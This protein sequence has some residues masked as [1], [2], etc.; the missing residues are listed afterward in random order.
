MAASLALR[1]VTKRLGDRLILDRVDVEVA[2]GEIVTVIGPNGSGKSTL[3]RIALGLLAPDGGA[4]ERRPGLRIGY[5]PQRVALSPLM[6]M[7]ARRFLA[8]HPGVTAAAMDRAF[9]LV[10]LDSGLAQT[11]VHHLSGGEFQRLLLARALL[12]E[13]SLLVLDEPTQGVDLTGQAAFYRL[14][15]RVR[16]ELQCAVLLISHDL[17]LVM[18]ATDRVVCL[19]HHVCCSGV[20]DKVRRDPAFRA[21]F[22][23]EAD[24]LALYAHDHAHA[25]DHDHDHDHDHEHHS[26]EGQA[27]G[28]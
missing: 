11:S 18:A 23:E 5:V 4:V 17:H 26:R 25:H 2:A 3:A 24:A 28:G 13:P 10:G 21:L 16:R 15:D 27:H 9:A 8:L 6:P 1:Q 20:P 14:I 19:N 22:G 7:T 12:A